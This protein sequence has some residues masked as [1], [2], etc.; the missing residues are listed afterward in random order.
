MK[1]KKNDEI[2]FDVPS[3]WH[4]FFFSLSILKIKYSTHDKTFHIDGDS[5]V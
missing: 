5:M 2:E 1:N 3:V 4:I